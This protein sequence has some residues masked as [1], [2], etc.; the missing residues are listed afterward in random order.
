MP[1]PPFRI[2]CGQDLDALWDES[3]DH[4]R[5]A[6]IRWRETGIIVGLS[7]N[8]AIASLLFAALEGSDG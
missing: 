1:R 6:A 2:S 8:T 4:L 3:G 7:V 5:L